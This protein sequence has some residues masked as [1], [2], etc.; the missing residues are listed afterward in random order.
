[1]K[2]I[3]PVL[4]Q[5]ADINPVHPRTENVPTALPLRAVKIPLQSD[6]LKIR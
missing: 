5:K 1:M 4:S 3:D 2:D 6:I